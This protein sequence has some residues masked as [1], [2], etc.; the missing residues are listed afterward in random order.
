MNEIMLREI[1]DQPAALERASV[2]L[3]RQVRE[4]DLGPP[5]R[6]VILTGS[7][8]SIIAGT[9]LESLYR[10]SLA[11]EVRAI[12]S[13]E[14]SR[15]EP[16]DQETL[17]VAV[18]VSG[19]VA[20]TVEAVL[21]A[22]AQGARALAVVA[23]PGSRLAE[24]AGAELLMPEPLARHTPHSRDYTQTLLA[25]AI[26]LERLA[27]TR[28]EQL[29][30]WPEA[31]RDVL[32]RAFAELPGWVDDSPQTIFLGAGP[33]RATARYGALKFWEGGAMRAIWD[34]L[35]EFAHGSQLMAAP[36]QSAVL[37]AGKEAHGR[38]EEFLAGLARMEI[39]ARLVIDQPPRSPERFV[40]PDLGG[41]AW[42]P[43]V[44]CLPLQ[45]LTYLTVQRRGIDL[46]IEMG[47]VPYGRL[48]GE[49][50]VQWTKH[51][52]IDADPNPG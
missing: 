33:D 19:G 42:M 1:Q 11:A 6:K 39:S 46:S 40:V 29:D 52:T 35:E 41:A 31:T 9:A 7:G 51:S 27:A 32:D 3:R 49:M 14:S 20:R 23:R 2:D 47:G 50:H 26:L 8:D 4:L 37:I 18:S 16:F 5:P 48:Y 44:S 10:R 13:M 12:S 45:V 34:E 22:R 24:A 21:R 28:F 38:A 15:Y 30:R 17:V 25:L 43:L 36:G